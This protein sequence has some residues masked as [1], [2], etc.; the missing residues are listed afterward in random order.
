M[1][2]YSND[3]LPKTVLLQIDASFIYINAGHIQI[4]GVLEDA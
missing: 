2:K 1:H 4:P 3:S